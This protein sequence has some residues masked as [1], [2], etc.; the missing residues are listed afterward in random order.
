MGADLLPFP[1][2]QPQVLS[3]KDEH[4][5]A[6]AV[7]ANG[8]HPLPGAGRPAGSGRRDLEGENR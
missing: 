2:T 8:N 6:A 1:E 3:Y 4:S 5:P 7:D